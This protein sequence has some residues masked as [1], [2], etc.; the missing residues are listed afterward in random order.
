MIVIDDYCND[1]FR[2]HEVQNGL[3]KTIIGNDRTDRR[4]A[5]KHGN[6]GTLFPR[7]KLSN[8]ISNS[9][10]TLTAVILSRHRLFCQHLSRLR[11]D[12]RRRIIIIKSLDG[13]Y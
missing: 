9:F 8:F 11:L 6:V 2:F 3:D 12:F 13:D 7:C 4:P 1:F 10:S 5:D